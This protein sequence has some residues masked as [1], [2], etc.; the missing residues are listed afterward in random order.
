MSSGWHAV[1]CHHGA[2]PIW[3]RG[4][5]VV[6]RGKHSPL[7]VKVSANICRA[8]K[9]PVVWEREV[10]L[11]C[12]FQ[13]LH[14]T[15]LI[16]FCLRIC[17]I[18]NFYIM[19][20][21]YTITSIAIKLLIFNSNTLYSRWKTLRNIDIV[22]LIQCWS[23]WRVVRLWE[24]WLA[25]RQVKRQSTTALIAYDA[26]LEIKHSASTSVKILWPYIQ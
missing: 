2:Q 6:A 22:T 3:T 21:L 11:K 23:W 12:L 4:Q 18:L 15:C 26:V 17:S 1:L 9:L 10:F 13:L 7:N 14:N 25:P 19:A 5:T 20:W 16:P 8:I 24:E